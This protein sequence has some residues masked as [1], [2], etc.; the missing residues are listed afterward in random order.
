M[1][2]YKVKLGRTTL[3]TRNWVLASVGLLAFGY[4]AYEYFRKRD[5]GELIA[6]G[7]IIAGLIMA[8]ASV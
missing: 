5:I 2:L 6:E 1:T 7:S 8:A 3:E 4:L